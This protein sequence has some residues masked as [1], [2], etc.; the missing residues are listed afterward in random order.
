MGVNGS[1]NEKLITLSFDNI[2][3][4]LKGNLGVESI[5]MDLDLTSIGEDKKVVVN[6]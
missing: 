3:A 2:L 5:V 4:V 1:L 6:F